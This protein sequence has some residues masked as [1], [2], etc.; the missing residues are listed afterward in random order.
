MRQRLERVGEPAWGR[1]TTRTF[2]TLWVYRCQ[3]LGWSFFQNSC[4]LPYFWEQ[5]RGWTEGPPVPLIRRLACCKWNIPLSH[6]PSHEKGQ[7]E[8]LSLILYGPCG[9][10][11]WTV[12]RNFGMF[13]ERDK[14]WKLFFMIIA[15]THIWKVIEMVFKNGY[16]SS[17]LLFFNMD[18]MSCHVII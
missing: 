13:R 3:G 15:V 14:N 16:E 8:F 10:F 2:Q 12:A 5:D 9:L 7:G 17:L 6:G 11:L 4:Y 18:V 1:A